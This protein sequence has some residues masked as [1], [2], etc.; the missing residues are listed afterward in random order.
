MTHILSQI[1]EA[2]QKLYHNESNFPTIVLGGDFN[3]PTISW[4]DGLGKVNPN[5]AYG[6]EVNYL[7][8]DILNDNHLEQLVTQPTR[9]NNILDLLFCTFPALIYK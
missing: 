9:G 8:I 6:L 7:L 2:L 1:G 3:L 5:P 4:D